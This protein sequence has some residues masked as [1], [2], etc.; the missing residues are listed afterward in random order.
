MKV[1]AVQ[2]LHNE[3]VLVKQAAE[4]LHPLVRQQILIRQY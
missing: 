3:A 1:F 4:E 2:Q